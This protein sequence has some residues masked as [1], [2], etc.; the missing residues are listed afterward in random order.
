MCT[1]DATYDN[2][3][4]CP[5]LPMRTTEEPHMVVSTFPLDPFGSVERHSVDEILSH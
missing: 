4:P 3:A 5:L 1:H 2:H